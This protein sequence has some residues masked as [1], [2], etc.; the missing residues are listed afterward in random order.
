M[1]RTNSYTLLAKL[2]DAF[3]LLITTDDET[4]IWN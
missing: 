2:E 4:A 1:E 3:A